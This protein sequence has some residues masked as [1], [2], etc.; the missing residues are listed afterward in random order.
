MGELVA[1][2][3]VTLGGVMQGLH[4]ADE[5][6]G[7]RH[8][9]WGDAYADEMQAEAALEEMPSAKAYLLGRRTY[10]ELAQFWPHQP[11]DNR[12][13]AYLKRTPK[14]VATRSLGELARPNTTPLEGE[15]ARAVAELTATTHGSIVVLGSR[16]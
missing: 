15:L 13:A 14:F 9:G 3:F 1:V 6:G 5:R 10:E 4:G 16:E 8:S 12:M 2:E 11:D 7:F